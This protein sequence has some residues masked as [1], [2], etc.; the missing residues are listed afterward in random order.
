MLM[1]LASVQLLQYA[2]G[3]IQSTAAEV[4]NMQLRVDVFCSSP[5]PACIVFVLGVTNHWVTLLAYKVQCRGGRG[6]NKQTEKIGLVYLDSNNVPVLT[7]SD[8]ELVKIV[9]GK[10]RARMKR[11]GRGYSE[12]KRRVILQAYTDQRDVVHL[13]AQVLCNCRNL[14]TELL[15]TNWTQI[16]NSYDEHVLCPLSGSED[17]EVYIPLLLQWLNHWPPQS[18]KDIHLNMLES[19]GVEHLDYKLKARLKSWLS[20]CQK[21]CNTEIDTIVLF[22][23]VLE[24]IRRILEQ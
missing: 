5:T 20:H 21:S 23:S 15:T 1:R 4:H 9:E 13:L 19:L 8:H 16:L 3:C 10:E 22:W 2:Y 18:F 17:R 14:C 7:A 24:D 12:W 11:K 6:N